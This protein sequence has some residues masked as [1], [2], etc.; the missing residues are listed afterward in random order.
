MKGLNSSMR[1]RARPGRPGLSL[2]RKPTAGIEP[3]RL[4]GRSH[5]VHYQGVDE[6]QQTIDVVEGRA[7]VAL[8]EPECLFL[9]HNQ[10]I[11]HIEIDVRRISLEA[12]QLIERVFAVKKLDL[13]GQPRG[14]HGALVRSSI[15]LAWSLDRP[16]QHGPAIGDFPCQDAF[17][18]LRRSSRSS[19]RL[20]CSLLRR[21]LPDTGPCTLAR[22]RPCSRQEAQAHLV[23]CAESHQIRTAPDVAEAD[24]AGDGMHGHA[25][26]H[27]AIDLD[28]HRLTLFGEVRPLG[29]DIQ[30]V[31]KLFH[32]CIP[33]HS[34]HS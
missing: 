3:D 26:T 10:M 2:W 28:H 6:G 11:E 18:D 23:F 31:E 25:Q 12:P 24:D 21:T 32:G 17:R 1:S 29:G 30:R 7:P 20:Y 34:R 19:A 33:P 27:V 15:L 13:P 4:Q 22:N 14:P 16:V 8:V 5:V 9:R